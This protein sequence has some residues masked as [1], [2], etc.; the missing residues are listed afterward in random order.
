[1]PPITVM[2]ARMLQP[3]KL[4]CRQKSR[5]RYAVHHGLGLGQGFAGSQVGVIRQQ[6]L[7]HGIAVGRHDAGND[8]QQRPEEDI[9]GLEQPGQGGGL[10]VGEVGEE[11][12]HR[13]PLP[14]Q[15]VQVEAG[16]AHAHHAAQGEEEGRQHQPHQQEI[17]N[18]A[19]QKGPEDGGAISAPGVDRLPE[20]PEIGVEAV[21]VVAEGQLR[22]PGD[23]APQNGGQEPR[24]DGDAPSAPQRLPGAG[25]EICRV[26][27]TAVLSAPESIPQTS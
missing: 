9:E 12:L 20:Q 16:V 7:R 21:V 24:Q 3:M 4:I 18:T 13:R 22:P 1:M 11:G 5:Q 15:K 2:L 14:V 8:Q 27:H 23:D 25:S 6:E 26:F 10:P 17:E 19:R